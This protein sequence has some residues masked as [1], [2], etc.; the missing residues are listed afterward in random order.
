MTLLIASPKKEKETIQQ[1]KNP[2]KGVPNTSTNGDPIH[3]RGD[4]GITMS[5]VIIDI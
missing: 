5:D 2:K 1:I 3:K 4:V